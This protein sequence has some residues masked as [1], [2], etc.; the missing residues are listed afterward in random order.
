MVYLTTLLRYTA[1]HHGSLR[2]PERVVIYLDRCSRYVRAVP[3]ITPPVHVKTMAE[4]HPEFDVVPGHIT[5]TGPARSGDR[6][7]VTVEQVIFDQRRRR[8]MTRTI[9]Q[10]VIL[11]V[12]DEVV[13]DVMT[14][15]IFHVNAGMR[16][17]RNLA[18]VHFQAGMPG[19]DAV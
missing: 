18:I 6:M 15:A 11:A 1:D 19:R 12:V 10:T 2:S 3:P 4:R 5:I 13:V 7:A 9:T 8:V 16:K 17:G 14:L